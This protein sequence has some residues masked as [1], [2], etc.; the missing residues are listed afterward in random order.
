[1]WRRH[2]GIAA[3]LL[4]VWLLVGAAVTGAKPWAAA[5]SQPSI[6]L[7]F[8]QADIRDVLRVLAE[9]SG[10]NIVVSPQVRGTVTVRLTDVA[11]EHALNA[12]LKLHG[13]AQE[14]QGNVVLIAPIEH[15]IAQ[16]Q[17]EVEARHAARQTGPQVT[18]LIPVKYRDAEELRAVIEQHLGAC[19]SVSA[20]RRTNTLILT[21][22]SSCLRGR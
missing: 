10:M 6:S 13:L 19:A 2:L 11:W 3:G 14:R 22:T 20:D 21:G 5:A 16:R 12:V 7:D 18:R 1:M 8:N 4:T 17:A 9:V 15:F